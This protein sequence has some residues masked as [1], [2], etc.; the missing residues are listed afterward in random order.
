MAEVTTDAGAKYNWTILL[1]CGHTFAVK[2]T[3]YLSLLL[4]CPDD[5]EIEFITLASRIGDDHVPAQ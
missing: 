2:A 4:V 1:S 5:G 3:P